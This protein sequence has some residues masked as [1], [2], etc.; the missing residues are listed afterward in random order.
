[1]K[2]SLY[3]ILVI[4]ALALLVAPVAGQGKTE[5]TW[6]V[7]L[8]TGTDAAQIEV[9][10]AVVEAFNASQDAIELKINI[11][12]SNQVAG[13]ALST[14][15]AAGTAPDIVGPVGFTGSN[16]F[17]G[18]WLDLQPLVDSSGYDLGQFPENLVNLYQ[19]SDGLLGIPFAVFPG[20]LY[21]NE[22]LFDEAGLNYPPSE[23]GAKYVMPDGSEVDW[24]WDTIAEICPILTVDANGNDATSADF[25]TDN[26]IQFGFNHQWGGTRSEFS[27]FGGAPVINP[28]SGKVEIPENWRAQAQ[29][30]HD[31]IWTKHFIPTATYDASDLFKPSAFASGNVAMARVM[32]W[33][34]CCLGDL[35]ANWDI[36]VVPS[37]NGTTFAPADADTFRVYK[38]TQNPEAAFTVLQYLLGDAA[39]DLLTV[40]GAYPARPDLQEASIQAKVEQYPTV[41]NW[42]IVPLSLE[43]ATVPHHESY[44]PG[45]N[46]GEARFTDYRTL[47]YGDT[48]ADM[49][50]NAELDK[51]QADL[52]SI[53]DQAG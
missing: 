11:A 21:Y 40:Y 20:L 39:L 12:A 6:F 19:E 50:V 51:L 17:A 25:D 29:W 4:A 27:T 46:K 32:L 14:L 18:Q 42:D 52:Q 26:V 44:Y 47:L 7:G 53:I 35:D 23:F 38:D 15:I 16:G 34:T 37:Y 1:M 13:D 2:K 9:Q 41:T 48:G 22:D 45:F 24:T 36:G 3:V 10:N 33:Y 49:D 8:G 31:G 28:D 5:V 30:L 43:Y